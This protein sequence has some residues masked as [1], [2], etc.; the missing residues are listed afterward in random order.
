MLAVFASRKPIA[1]NK[2]VYMYEF[3]GEFGLWHLH[4]CTKC[5]FR[6]LYIKQLSCISIKFN[7]GSVP[8]TMQRDGHEGSGV[9]ASDRS[10]SFKLQRSCGQ[11]VHQGNIAHH[12]HSNQYL[13]LFYLPHQVNHFL[14]NCDVAMMTTLP[15]SQ[16]LRT[17]FNSTQSH[18]ENG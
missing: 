13:L 16:T 7:P 1:C 18:H 8:Q 14:H 11:G 2:C 17:K 5:D 15:P 9:I 12:K 3:D 6:N 4:K 10:I